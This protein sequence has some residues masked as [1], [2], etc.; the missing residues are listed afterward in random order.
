MT[1]PANPSA[2][3]TRCTAHLG[4]FHNIDFYLALPL[5]V[6]SLACC[7]FDQ[8][9][10]SCSSCVRQMLRSPTL[11]REALEKSYGG[12]FSRSEFRLR[13]SLSVNRCTRTQQ[14]WSASHSVEFQDNTIPGFRRV[15]ADRGTLGLQCFLGSDRDLYVML[16]SCACAGCSCWQSALHGLFCC[17][18]LYL[19]GYSVF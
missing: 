12:S 10:S 18:I 11:Y 19:F 16:C 7:I 13:C 6:Y 17:S 15:C 1:R 2:I 3:L 4:Q 9:R 14:E 5:V 8:P